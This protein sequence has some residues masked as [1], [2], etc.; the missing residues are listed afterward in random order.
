MQ[1]KKFQLLPTLPVKD[2]SQGPMN[3]KTIAILI[4]VFNGIR[5][6]QKCL[7]SLYGIF[8]T[9]GVQAGQF[10]VVVIDDGSADGTREW[11][12]EHYPQTTILSG[13]GNLWWSGG[14]N[15]GIEY[16]LQT[17]QCDFTLW[18]NNDIHCAED[19]FINL[20][21]IAEEIPE[22]VI[23]G[24]KIYYAD[25]QNILWS[26]GGK[27]DPRNGDKYVVGMNEADSPAF[28]LET[29]ADWLP[30]MGTLIHRSVYEKT[31]MVNAKEF[32]Q[33]HGDSDFTYRAKLKGFTLRVYP[34]LRI[35]N[36]KTNSGLQKID[37]F[38]VLFR[39]LSDIRSN[40]HLGKDLLFYR[41]Y[42]GSVLAYRPLVRKY[43]YYI[44]G[45]IK[46]WAL[47]M[48]GIRKPK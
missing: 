9:M 31:G 39:S 5:F 14:I 16:A 35:W 34:Q 45:F 10:K 17:L 38:G 23:A 22:K 6:T 27:F 32:P 41:Y 43:F 42:A 26:M 1:Q 4:P 12:E 21:R 13:D 29:E 44:G 20:V 19:Y 40:Y 48:A 18:W 46:W 28:Q 33:Y 47:G 36:D 7:N 25:E 24:S 30:G 3:G 15:K 11:V 37:N 2:N 8:S